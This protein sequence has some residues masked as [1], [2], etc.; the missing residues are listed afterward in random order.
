MRLNHFLCQTKMFIPRICGIH[1]VKKNNR[2]KFFGCEKL[3][4]SLYTTGKNASSHKKC[5]D[6]PSLLKDVRTHLPWLGK[7]PNF[8]LYIIVGAV[9]VS[10]WLGNFWLLCDQDFR[11][12]WRCFGQNWK[13]VWMVGDL[14]WGNRRP[15]AVW[16][17][18]LWCGFLFHQQRRAKLAT[19][20]I[21]W[22]DL[23]RMS[24]RGVEISLRIK[25]NRS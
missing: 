1:Q 9:L 17:S 25:Q 14:L 13:R 11:K 20:V 19:T 5:L 15:A 3:F 21:T 24:S 2:C 16:A 12:K 7:I 6:C 23:A 18:T 8:C 22:L 4:L 10:G